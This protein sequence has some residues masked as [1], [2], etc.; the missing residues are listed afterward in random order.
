MQLERHQTKLSDF[1][2]YIEGEKVIVKSLKSKMDLFQDPIEFK[3]WII[4][5]I[6][7]TADQTRFQW[8]AMVIS[9]YR[10]IFGKIHISN[11][12]PVSI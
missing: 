11:P 8:E 1:T 2:D 9:F 7:D 10:L 5:C 4:K 12:S 3:K 6:K